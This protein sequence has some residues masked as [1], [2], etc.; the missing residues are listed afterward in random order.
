MYHRGT[1]K[2]SNGTGEIN[3]KK[4]Y[5]VYIC[6]PKT[7]MEAMIKVWARTRDEAIRIATG[8]F[9]RDYCQPEIIHAKAMR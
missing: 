1:E 6:L 2:S 3:M 4:Q 7:S 5:E 9:I 8:Q